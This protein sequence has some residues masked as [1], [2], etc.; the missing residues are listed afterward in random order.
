[1]NVMSIRVLTYQQ[2]RGARA[3]LDITQADLARRAGMS[4]T[5]LHAIERG[6]SDPKASTLRAIQR[7]LEAAGAEFDP[8]GCGVWVRPRK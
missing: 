2:I 1:M 4:K 3:M 6:K 8:E 7:A 5:A